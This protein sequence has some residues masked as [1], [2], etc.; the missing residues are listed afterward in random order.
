MIWKYSSLL[1]YNTLTEIHNFPQ[2]NEVTSK[3]YT[4]ERWHGASFILKAQ[5]SG[6]TCEPH[7]YLRRSARYM[8]WRDVWTTL[9][10]AAFCS[11]HVLER[12]V[13]HIVICG[14]LLGTCVGET[15]EPHCNPEHFSVPVSWYTILHVGK[16]TTAT[17][18]MK[19]LGA[20]LYKFSHTSDEAPGICASLLTKPPPRKIWIGS[21]HR[22]CI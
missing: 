19:I 20:I 9:L 4:P 2:N 15:C 14:V 10:S 7:C 8:C 12:P 21:T 6:V 13:N 3:F 1:S 22:V 17:I 5:N 18:M 11:V 16:K